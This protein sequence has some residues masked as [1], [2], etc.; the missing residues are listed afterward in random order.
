MNR[1]DWLNP[2]AFSIPAPGESGNLKRGALRGPGFA[3]VD[4]V[5][6]KRFGLGFPRANFRT[7]GARRNPSPHVTHN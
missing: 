7:P 2:A 1:R 5:I 3:Q 6:A 4:L